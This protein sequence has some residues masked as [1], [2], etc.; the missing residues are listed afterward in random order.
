LNTKV[1][2]RDSEFAQELIEPQGDEPG[3]VL[4]NA[5]MANINNT[6]EH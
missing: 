6:F 5:L 1:L 3:Q 2:D 4:D